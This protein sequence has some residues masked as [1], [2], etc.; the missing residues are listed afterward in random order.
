[1]RET[2]YRVGGGGR[3]YLSEMFGLRCKETS[4]KRVKMFIVKIHKG[5]HGEV[6]VISDKEIM[7]K[8][9]EEGKLQLD[10]SKEFYQGE[11]MDDEKIKELVK[12][13]YILHLTGKK[14]VKFFVDLGLVNK[15][16]VLFVDG[17]PHAEVCLVKE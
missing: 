17:V 16:N 15:E 11:E 2:R 9:F 7:G 14:V 8:R 5:P 10:L 13:A 1:M 4:E 6:L 3:N 12:S